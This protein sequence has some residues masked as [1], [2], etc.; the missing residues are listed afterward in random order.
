M[1]DTSPANDAWLG[2]LID[3]SPLLPEASLR[4][5]WRR[6][7]P[8]LSTGARYELAAVLLDVEHALP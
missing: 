5:H 3:R 1:T 8:W 2:E 6:L 4:Q 7:L